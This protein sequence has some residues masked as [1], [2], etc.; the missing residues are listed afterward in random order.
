MKNLNHYV[1]IYQKQLNK[2]DILIA[3]NGL[4]KFVMKLRMD[5]TKRLTDSYTFSGMPNGYIDYTYFYYSNDYLKSRK[6]KLG[7]VLNHLEMR[8]EIWL[9]G[10]TKAVQKKYWFLLKESKWN[11][12]RPEMPKYAILEDII[13][14]EP[15]FNDLA[16]LS[17]TI[18]SKLV[19]VSEEIISTIRN[20]KA[21]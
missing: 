4:M 5:L 9:L 13:E 2:G 18:E 21:L 12:G 3:H 19:D 1:S 15:D 14:S 16:E 6:L 8:F 11:K 20:L 7:L 10:N 17:K